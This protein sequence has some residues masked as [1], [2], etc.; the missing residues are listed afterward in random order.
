[1]IGTYEANKVCFYRIRGEK[2]HTKEPSPFCGSLLCQN[3]ELPS[4]KMQA[5]RLNYFIELLLSSVNGNC[6]DTAVFLGNISDIYLL[7]FFNSNL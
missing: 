7:L 1:M 5:T 3:S 2:M 4:D 6:R